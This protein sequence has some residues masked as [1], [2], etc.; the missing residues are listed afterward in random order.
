MAV[1]VM[2]RSRSLLVDWMQCLQLIKQLNVNH[3]SYRQSVMHIACSPGA[4]AVWWCVV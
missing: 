4:D 3:R 2:G 1:E